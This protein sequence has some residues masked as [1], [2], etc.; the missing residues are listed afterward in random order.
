MSGYYKLPVPS[1]YKLRIFSDPSVDESE[2]E[3]ATANDPF[4]GLNDI[5]CKH[6][7]TLEERFPFD[8]S[9]SICA[10]SS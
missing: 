7:L 2:I 6:L 3:I 1:P 8:R 5:N 10:H 4:A 9:I